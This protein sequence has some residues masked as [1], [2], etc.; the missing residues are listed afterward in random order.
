MNDITADTKCF[1]FNHPTDLFTTPLFTE[2]IEDQTEAETL[3]NVIDYCIE[4][5][6][7]T[8][9][10]ESECEAIIALKSGAYREPSNA[11][12]I[13]SFTPAEICAKLRQTA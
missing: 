10:W 4:L 1:S 13:F 7:N 3:Q 11:C 8:C 2:G 6:W 12:E 9:L 5:Q